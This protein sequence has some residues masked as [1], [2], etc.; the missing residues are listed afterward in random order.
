MDLIGD[1]PLT[2]RQVGGDRRAASADPGDATVSGSP[3]G[4]AQVVLTLST[5]KRLLPLPSKSMGNRTMVHD[6]EPGPPLIIEAEHTFVEVVIL[7]M[8]S[9][10]DL[11]RVPGN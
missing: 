6:R 8:I 11:V 5:M 4:S 3:R 1:P 7:R 2:G 10:W 9:A